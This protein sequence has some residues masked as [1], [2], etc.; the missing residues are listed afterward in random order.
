[1]YVHPC[2]ILV[3]ISAFRDETKPLAFPICHI[4]GHMGKCELYVLTSRIYIYM[5]VVNEIKYTATPAVASQC[6]S[7]Y[8]H[9]NRATVH[10]ARRSKRCSV[11]STCRCSFRSRSCIHRLCRLVLCVWARMCISFLD[12]KSGC[13]CSYD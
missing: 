4:H 10:T 3:N 6:D 11:W 13:P 7:T 8:I 2:N 9:I 12:H 1:M 5:C